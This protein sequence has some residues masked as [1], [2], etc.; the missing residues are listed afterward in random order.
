MQHLALGEEKR[1]IRGDGDTK[2]RIEIAFRNDETPTHVTGI[3][4][5]RVGEELPSHRRLRAVCGDKK[6]GL[7]PGSVAEDGRNARGRRLDAHELQPRPI[8]IRRKSVLERPVKSA[9]GGGEARRGDLQAVGDP[10][11]LVDA[12]I[13]AGLDRMGVRASWLLMA[14]P[15]PARSLALRS[16]TM[17][18]QPMRR[19]RLAANS[20]AS[21]PPMTK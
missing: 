16:Q 11:A 9:P 18:F 15:R 5:L 7:D 8:A 20:P 12:D 1:E 6:I 14:A 13:R 17:T 21:E 4:G 19:R 2:F 3:A 10:T